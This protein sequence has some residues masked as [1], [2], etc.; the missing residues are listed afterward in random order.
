M[1]RIHLLLLLSCVLAGL[2]TSVGAQQPGDAAEVPSNGKRASEIVEE[3]RV[4]RLVQ[5][6]QL[7]PEVLSQLLRVFEQAEQERLQAD[8]RAVAGMQKW[9]TSLQNA[10]QALLN[11]RHVNAISP[12]EE[13][14]AAA[15]LRLDGQQRDRLLHLAQ[16]VRKTLES[17]LSRKERAAALRAGMDLVRERRV[18]NVSRSYPQRLRTALRELERVRSDKN[19]ASRRLRFALSSARIP[20]WWVVPG[21]Y[22]PGK[23]APNPARLQPPDLNDPTIQAAIQPLLAMADQARSATPAAYQQQKAQ[24]VQQLV[25]ARRDVLVNLPVSDEEAMEAFIA[26]LVSRPP[27]V[28]ISAIRLK[29]GRQQ[30]Q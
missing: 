5:K 4:L 6:A 2:T 29:L 27:A 24:L 8:A 3:I 7:G 23:D 25:S 10:K 30:G 12:E 20:N 28:A 19:Y 22:G 26:A 17:S 9:E 21:L 16:A 11:G 15:Q 13:A 18:V 1:R 14:F